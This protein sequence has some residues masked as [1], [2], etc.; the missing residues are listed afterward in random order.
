MIYKI[1]DLYA[2]SKTIDTPLLGDLSSFDFMTDYHD[3]YK[4]F[5]RLIGRTKGLFTPILQDE[6]NGSPTPALVD[7]QADVF[8]LIYKHSNDLRREYEINSLTYNPID[9][10]NS[11]ETS[12]DTHTID[13]STVN[14][15]GDIDTNR[16]L[17][18]KADI[19]VVGGINSEDIIGASTVTENIGDF[20]TDENIRPHTDITTNSVCGFNE[21]TF[22]NS[23][24][25]TNEIDAVD[26][27]K[28]EMERENVTTESE[29][30]NKSSIDSRTD[31]DTYGK[32]EN[33]ESIVKGNDTTTNKKEESIT[34]TLNKKGNIGVTTT[35]QMIK[36]EI[37]LWASFN[38]Y[39]IVIDLIIKELCLLIDEED[40]NAF[41]ICF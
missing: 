30:T 12:Q 24:R 4:Y 15:Y 28:H 5:D 20:M 22:N 10:Y 36:S 3:N 17:G 6:L 32:Q 13:D 38:F 1:K 11:T 23:T 31:T 27:T 26:T 2:L 18:E 21:T 33:Y 25:V 39:T 8:A 9:N 37:D 14:S 34:H 16:V 40:N 7:F 29:K 19:H 41:D 35:Q